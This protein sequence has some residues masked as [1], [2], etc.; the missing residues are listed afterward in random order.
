M[1]CNFLSKKNLFFPFTEC[2][3]AK[4]FTH[5]PFT[6][7]FPCKVSRSLQVIPGPCSHMIKDDFLSN[8]ST[9]K[10]S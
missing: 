2:D 3:R 6:Y 4:F 8:P 10:N 7:H 1:P 9:H 5:T